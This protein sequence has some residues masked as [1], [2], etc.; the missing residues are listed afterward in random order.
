MVKG[1]VAVSKSSITSAQH[2]ILAPIGCAMPTPMMQAAVLCEHGDIDALR[3]MSWPVPTATVGEVRVRVRAAALNRADLS[4]IRGLSGP[5]IRP[6]HL[7]LIPGVDLA[8]EI[9]ALG[10]G[11]DT[12]QW[13][14][15]DRVVAYPGVFC[16]TCR[17]CE[18]GEESMC[19]R[20]QII[21]EERHGGFA[22]YTV[23][24][25]SNLA[26]VPD[27]V[28]FDVAAAAPATFTTAWR[29]LV[30]CARLTPGDTVLV[31]GVGSGVSTAAIAIARRVGATVLGTTSVPAKADAARALGASAVISGYDEPFDDWVME[32]TNH[33]G[34]DVVIDSVGAATWRSSIR[35]LTPGGA[36]VVCGATSGDEPSISIRELYQHHRRILGAPLGNRREFRRVMRLV[37]DGELVP[38]IDRRYPLTAIGE[39]LERLA[40]REQFGK[41]VVLP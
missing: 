3:V 30:T 11:V 12:A 6:K 32:Q 26:R 19:E 17:A 24:P 20:Y 27:G 21:G 2:P 7:P 8:G 39:A 40:N 28:P 1:T 10:K 29:M 18:R 4:I 33:R 13:A 37:F 16:G 5:G 15:G 38:V 25:A 22:E 35:S 34:V 23:V 31:V 41:V 14:V 36:L 9:D